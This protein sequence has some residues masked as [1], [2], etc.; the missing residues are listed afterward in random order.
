MNDKSDITWFRTNV[1]V[2][3]W[4]ILFLIVKTELTVSLTAVLTSQKDVIDI[5]NELL[6]GNN[7][8][9]NNHVVEIWN[10]KSGSSNS[11]TKC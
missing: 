11:A 9:M 10:V 3:I 6:I 2:D 1:I 5:L 4:N 7:V 8:I